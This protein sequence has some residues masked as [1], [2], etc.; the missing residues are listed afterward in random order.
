LANNKLVLERENKPVKGTYWR[1][2]SHVSLRGER[3]SGDQLAD[4]LSTGNTHPKP[5]EVVDPYNKRNKIG[6]FVIDTITQTVWDKQLERK[7]RDHAI[8]TGPLALLWNNVRLGDGISIGE[9]S[10]VRPGAQVHDNAKIG[11]YSHLGKHGVVEAGAE[12]GGFVWIGP[13][14]QIR[15]LASVATGSVFE[16]DCKVGSSSTVGAQ[17]KM[18]KGVELGRDVWMDDR[19]LLERYT[20]INA[21]AIIGESVHVSPYGVVGAGAVVGAEAVIGEAGS[22]MPTGFVLAG[23][24]VP[25][26]QQ[27]Q[28][29]FAKSFFSHLD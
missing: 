6:N 15:K 12:V 8:T 16:K 24:V 20:H 18:Q 27:R 29:E 4:F 23:Q 9:L 19:V 21:G 5:I 3:L 14:A 11:I 22:V 2:A 13:N 10:E 1:P 26:R 25:S 7:H 17:T 28:D